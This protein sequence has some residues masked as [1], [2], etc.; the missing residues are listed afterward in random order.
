M[1]LGARVRWLGTSRFVSDAIGLLENDL[2][3]ITGDESLGHY[4]VYVVGPQ[5]RGE[6]GVAFI[7]TGSQ[8]SLV[9]ELSLL[10]Y[11][12]NREAEEHKRSG[13]IDN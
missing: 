9:K 7:D 8:V 1:Q 6:L 11:T 3:E 2:K 4:E 5:L 13:R 10:A 12:K